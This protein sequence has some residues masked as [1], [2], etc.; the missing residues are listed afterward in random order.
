[1]TSNLGVE[2]T[3]RPIGFGGEINTVDADCELEKSV[4]TAAKRFF[5]PEFIN[6]LTGIVVFRPLEIDHVHQILDLLILRLNERLKIKGVSAELTPDALR[7]LIQEGYSPAYGARSLERTLE[8][9]VSTPLSK[10]LL[11]EPRRESGAFRIDHKIGDK[12]LTIGKFES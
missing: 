8:K 1:M 5:R 11:E 3:C 12:I 10:I 9:E 4:Q 2:N 6:R 7:F